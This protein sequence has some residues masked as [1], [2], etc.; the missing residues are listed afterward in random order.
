MIET[1][2][3]GIL[4]IIYNC[5]ILGGQS[6]KRLQETRGAGQ[7]STDNHTELRRLICCGAHDLV[8]AKHSN[9]VYY[10]GRGRT[11]HWRM[12]LRNHG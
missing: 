2:G 8:L 3:F 6:K 11:W 5:L 12:T 1:W 4:N 9:F 7:L 10:H